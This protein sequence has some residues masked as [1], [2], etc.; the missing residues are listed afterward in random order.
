[1]PSLRFF[2]PIKLA[3]LL[4]LL[5]YVGAYMRMPLLPLYA[6]AGGASTGQVGLLMGAFTVVAATSEGAFHL[7]SRS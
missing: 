1:M 3:C 4:V 5:H 7:V 6:R 2:P